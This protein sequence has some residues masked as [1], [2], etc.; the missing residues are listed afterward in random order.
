MCHVKVKPA[1]KSTL[2]APPAM[3]VMRHINMRYSNKN[4]A[5]AFM[6]EYILNPQK[7]KS[8]C[9]PKS[10]KRFGLMPSQKE[11]VTVDEAKI[12]TAWM[13]D[14]I[15][16]NKMKQKISPFLISKGLPHMTKL[17]M[18]NW[19]SPELNL[20]KEQKKRLTVVKKETMKGV[21]SVKP[22]A[23]KLEKEIKKLTLHGGDIK[24]INSLIDRLAK[25]KAKAS[26][27]H[28]KC[29]Q[30]TKAI[31]NKKQLHFLMGR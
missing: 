29:I 21:K 5:V 12:I 25:I 1:D 20:S 15:K 3:G 8:V 13:Y 23:I 2:V 28:V 17:V 19:D 22:K 4:D 10:I 18:M 11:N 14:N 7:E 31:L 16:P 26:K 6:S 30:D 27:I 24:K 9:K